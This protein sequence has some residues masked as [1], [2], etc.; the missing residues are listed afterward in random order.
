MIALLRIMMP[1]INIAA[2][3]ALQAIDPV[4][5][6]N[7][8]KIGANVVMPNITPTS[9][10]TLYKLYENKPGIHEGAKE[11]MQELET[12][13]RNSGCNIQY[14]VWGDSLHFQYKKQTISQE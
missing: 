14:G 4:G 1:N 13:I 12:T 11:S 9:N 8:L 6:E 10:R 3:T 5:R 7:A 2:T